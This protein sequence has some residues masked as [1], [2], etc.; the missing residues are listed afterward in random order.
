MVYEQ[1]ANVSNEEARAMMKVKLYEEFHNYEELPATEQYHATKS[2]SVKYITKHIPTFVGMLIKGLF[3]E[4]VAPNLTGIYGL[5]VPR[6]LQYLIVCAK[7]GLLLLSY[8]IYAVGFLRSLFYQ[9]WLD[10]LILLSVMYLMAST[11]PLG[12]SRFRI[13]FYLLCLIGTFTCWKGE[14]IKWKN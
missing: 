9:K 14:H 7:A 13:V 5:P 6:L 12:Y 3:T 1:E 10:W 11:A 4:M 2:V 8:L